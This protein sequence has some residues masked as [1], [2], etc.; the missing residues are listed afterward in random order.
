[1]EKEATPNAGLW[2][3]HAV[4]QWIQQHISK[5]SGDPKTVTAMGISAGA[6]SI[7]HHLVF[8]G[9]KRDPLFTR[10]I[11][12]S[13]GYQ[14]SQDR[15]GQLEQDFKR[16]EGLAGCKGKGLPCL[17]ALSESELKTASDKA[18]AGLRTGQF[19]FSPAPDGQLIKRVPTIE[20]ATGGVSVLFEM[21]QLTSDPGNFFKGIETIISSH[22]TDEGSSFTD[23]T[24]N[25][26]DKFDELMA[27]TYGNSSALASSRSAINRL[28]PPVS[29]PNSPFKTEKQR[30][31]LY[32]TEG[33]FTCHNRVVADAYAGKTYVVHYA[34][35][36]ARHGG[37]QDATF[38]NPLNPRYAST[39]A[40]ELEERQ[41]FQSYLASYIR[42]GNPN[43]YRNNAT[44][45]EWP[46]ATG[47]GEATLGNALTI[48]T[49]A[50]K[51]G[52]KVAADSLMARERCQWWTDALKAKENWLKVS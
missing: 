49:L 3:Q 14:N 5:F 25:T 6:G 30:L 33:S 12:Q 22:V 37:D 38:F 44:T 50:G 23:E 41:G 40:A 10:A 4:L 16:F 28:Y 11:L 9:G 2:D 36:P 45:I 24:V 52:I 20:L 47:Y 39:P 13:P 29:A 1:M 42:S 32:V 35:P 48:E 26:D 51:A 31:G 34:V 43:T 7:Q 46:F 27:L 8:E 19:A 15:P 18:N 21:K 17:R